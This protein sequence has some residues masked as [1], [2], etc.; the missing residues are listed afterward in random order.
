MFRRALIL[1]LAL[2]LLL[3]ADDP[4]AKTQVEQPV[5]DPIEYFGAEA[6]ATHVVFIIDRSMSMFFNP[7]D[8][9]EKSKWL[10]MRDGTLK[11][12]DSL[13][14]TTSFSLFFFAR[15][16]REWKPGFSKATQANKAAAKKYV[17]KMST[18][19]PTFLWMAIKRGFK[20]FSDLP[21]DEQTHAKPAIFILT[22]GKVSDEAE[23]TIR[24][25]IKP[26]LAKWKPTLNVVSFEH[27]SKFLEALAKENG[28]TLICPLD[29][30][31]DPAK[32]K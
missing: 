1:A 4:P 11:T 12:I 16:T 10:I 31:K 15:D 14:E 26:L 25:G 24:E 21:A 19:G 28:G 29:Q 17:E 2:P 32:K 8:E 3:R 27:D 9:P 5:G 20:Y 7:K 23:K 13:K 18:G 6:K 22:D 30:G